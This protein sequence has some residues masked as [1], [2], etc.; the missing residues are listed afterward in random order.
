MTCVVA[1]E[2]LLCKGVGGC[3]GIWL[4]S[5]VLRFRGLAGRVRRLQ[6]FCSYDDGSGVSE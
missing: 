1:Q 2:A 4:S 6:G 5:A 3:G